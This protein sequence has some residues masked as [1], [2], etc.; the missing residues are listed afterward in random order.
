VNGLGATPETARRGVDL[1]AD[2]WHRTAARH[3]KFK[4]AIRAKA[5]ALQAD[6]EKATATNDLSGWSIPLADRGTFNDASRRGSVVVRSIVAVYFKIRTTIGVNS[7]TGVR[8]I[9]P[10][11]VFRLRNGRPVE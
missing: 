3:L 7:P 9:A 5:A 2:R 4:A 6:L 10:G 8:R 11:P 1:T